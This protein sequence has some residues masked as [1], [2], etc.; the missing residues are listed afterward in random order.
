[1]GLEVRPSAYRLGDPGLKPGRRAPMGPDVLL[2]EEVELFLLGLARDVDIAAR[3]LSVPLFGRGLN[4]GMMSK[5]TFQVV[6]YSLLPRKEPSEEGSRQSDANK[7]QVGCGYDTHSS[8]SG[9]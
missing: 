3:P 7:D 4:A 1:M 5:S 2:K 6:R 8:S 9:S